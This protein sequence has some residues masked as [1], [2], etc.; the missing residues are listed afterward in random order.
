MKRGS[1]AS[2][3]LIALLGACA[4]GTG[5]PAKS[6]GEVEVPQTFTF[7]TSRPV[8]LEVVASHD[9][10]GRDVG[11]L[12]VTRTDGRVLFK[13]PLRADQPVTL[14]VSVPQKDDSI[15]LTLI[16]ND[17]RNSATVDVTGGRAAHAFR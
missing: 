5:S 6:L 15:N 16:N 7:A 4:D 8:E 14:N 11:A 10:I 17:A 9:A 12:E 1:W 3:A 13:G 2:I